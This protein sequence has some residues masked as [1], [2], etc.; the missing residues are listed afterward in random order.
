MFHMGCKLTYHLKS[1][2]THSFVHFCMETSTLGR[3]KPPQRNVSDE[4]YLRLINFDSSFMTNFVYVFYDYSFTS[5]DS[6]FMTN[7]MYVFSKKGTSE[8]ST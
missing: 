4:Q 8:R 7:F 5:F 6:S 2:G 1:R 3:S